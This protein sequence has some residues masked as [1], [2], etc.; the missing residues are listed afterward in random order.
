MVQRSPIAE[1]SGIQMVV[2]IAVQ[3]SDHHS[4]NGLPTWQ[5]P[6]IVKS[7]NQMFPFTKCPV[8]GSPLCS[9]ILK[10]K[11]FFDLSK[12]GGPLPS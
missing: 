2:W 4:V 5:L 1:L 8:F 3:Y 9:R 12:F 10:F 11:E 6:T 7:A